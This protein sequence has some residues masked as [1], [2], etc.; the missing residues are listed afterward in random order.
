MAK[1]EELKACYHCGDAIGR[2]DISYDGKDFCC[3]GCQTV[4]EILSQNDLCTY[5]DLDANPGISLKSKKFDDQYAYLDNEEIARLV[6]DYKD[7][8]KAKATFFIPTI[9]CS[10]CIWLLE[11]LYRLKEGVSYSRVN[12][13]KKE[14]QVDFEPS[15]I[16]LRELVE[17]L[18]KLGYEPHIS[19]D[20]EAGKK[21]R[22]LNRSL[23]LKIGIAFFCFGNIML[24][25]FPE[26]FGFEGLF[27]QHI[28]KFISYLNIALSLPVF[29]Y[30]ASDYYRSAWTG[31][32]KGFVNI[33][34]PISL[35]VIVLFGRSLY[36]ILVLG[37]AGYLDSLAGLL[38]FLL[39]GRWFQDYTYQGLSFER[40]YRSYFPLA[41]NKKVQEGIQ[42]V[43][44]TQ[45]KKGDE[46]QVR[47]EEVIPA[48]CILLSEQA[49]IDYS[50]VTGESEPVAKKKGDFIYAGGRQ[51]G[52]L[53][54]LE[55]SKEVSQSYL[56]RLWNHDAFAKEDE[57]KYEGIV[58]HF[59]KYFTTSVIALALLAFG[60]WYFQG[61]MS[62][63]INALTAVLIVA[64]PCALTLSAPFTLG[65]TM[66]VLGKV[67]LY[68]KNT[69]IIE[70]FYKVNHIVFDKTGTI[71][72]NQST[73]IEYSGKQ[74]QES[75]LSKIGELVSNSTHPISQKL[76]QYL[77]QYVNEGDV[78]V[79][80]YQ[81]VSG[82]GV[83]GS[84]GGS[85]IKLGNSQFVDAQILNNGANETSPGV[86][87]SINNEFKGRFSFQNTFRKGL[88][89]IVNKF[90]S[91]FKLSLVSG[92]NDN[93][94]DRLS[95][96]FPADS[97][98]LFNMSPAD[99]L[100]YIQ[101]LQ[102]K[103]NTVLMLGDGLNDAGALKQ[104]NVGISVTEQIA[105]FTPASDAI[106]AAR[107]FTWLPQMM[108]FARSSRMIILL[109]FTISLLYNVVG[110]S[111]AM[112]GSLSPLFAAILMPLSSVTVVSFA[113]IAVN[114]NAR[115]KKL[116]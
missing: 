73:D 83:S 20:T 6:L 47:N 42:S 103:S 44:V 18:A 39:V 58:N 43:P 87:V 112:S 88:R 41:V 48:D 10:S 1:V 95:T 84:I 98:L 96:I 113:T 4:Y 70:R 54:E 34:I 107:S 72:I 114:I 5:Y 69:S 85:L 90:V 81:E 109:S 7:D 65:N 46:I 2:N 30:C 29:F 89:E 52:V 77:L 67:G 8:Q 71:T 64:C 60:Y 100:K 36:E 23:Y 82:K 19:L 75:E 59:S 97:E 3:H 49:N 110:L 116:M 56:T 92:D 86:L 76:S 11:N 51:K 38:F 105:Q 28:K 80:E 45:L 102:Q 101:S 21:Q 53:I 50:F 79:K 111:F 106:L 78:L 24:L 94:K 68:L 31:I 91:A 25:S 22:S 26:Y 62:V 40:D 12:F 115:I 74:L 61:E 33:D 104:A 99:K 13:V 15:K 17:L 66:R 32:R 93:E 9:H 14:L 37:Q 35:G 57:S 55:V 108:D 16:G 27:D 63:A